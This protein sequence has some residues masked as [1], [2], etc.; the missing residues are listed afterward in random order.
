MRDLQH[1]IQHLTPRKCAVNSR[2]VP[3]GGLMDQESNSQGKWIFFWKGI[4][5][6]S[7]GLQNLPA[8][9]GLQ[10]ISGLAVGLLHRWAIWEP[11]SESD[12]AKPGSRSVLCP[13]S[14]MRLHGAR[15]AWAEASGRTSGVWRDVRPESPHC[16]LGS[17]CSRLPMSSLYKLPLQSLPSSP[18]PC[19]P[20][21]SLSHPAGD[22]LKDVLAAGATL[23]NAKEWLW[24]ILFITHPILIAM[25]LQLQK[26]VFEPLG[27][28]LCT[29]HTMI[30]IQLL[31]ANGVCFFNFL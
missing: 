17:V 20:F 4:S 1:L 19:L 11:K 30:K 15:V 14:A 26:E 25:L 9:R 13:C 29:H 5:V 8:W 18:Q 10:G 3:S 27:V 7:L 12:L 21:S 24:I 6:G 23:E 28:S 31:L 2:V 16:W 22:T